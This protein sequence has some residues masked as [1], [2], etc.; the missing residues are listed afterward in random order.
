MAIKLEDLELGESTVQINVPKDTKAEWDA[1]R[2]RFKGLNKDFPKASRAMLRT[3]IDDCNKALDLAS[4]AK[5]KSNGNGAGMR[6][7]QE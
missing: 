5:S 7:A 3:F 6:A 1:L 2:A 4:K